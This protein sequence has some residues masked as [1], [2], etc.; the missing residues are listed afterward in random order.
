MT[1]I[2]VKLERW[3]KIRSLQIDENDQYYIATNKELNNENFSVYYRF[4]CGEWSVYSRQN[5]VLAF[6]NVMTPIITFK[7]LVFTLDRELLT[8]SV[9]IVNKQKIDQHRSVSSDFINEYNLREIDDNYL[10]VD[11]HYDNRHYS[12]YLIKKENIVLGFM[13][14]QH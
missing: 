8:R 12:V 13:L 14:T 6:F 2:T 1:E 7:G 5:D 10:H 9:A 4:K 3:T 11:A